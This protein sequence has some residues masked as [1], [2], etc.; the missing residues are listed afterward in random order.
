MIEIHSIDFSIMIQY[1][2]I[3]QISKKTIPWYIIIWAGR[4]DDVEIKEFLKTWKGT[5]GNKHSFL[6]DY[7]GNKGQTEIC[8][9]SGMSCYLTTS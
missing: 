1:V 7:L 2:L 3:L 5:I 8:V 6:Y 4:F 9:H